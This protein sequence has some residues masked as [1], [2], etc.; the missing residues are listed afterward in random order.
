[1]VCG[2]WHYQCSGRTSL[3][4]QLGWITMFLSPAGS[5]SNL[6]NII[7]SLCDGF[8]PLKF[9]WDWCLSKNTS[10]TPEP[11]PFLV[12]GQFS[13]SRV[14]PF[15]LLRYLWSWIIVHN[16]TWHKFSVNWMVYI[17]LTTN[18]TS[19]GIK[20]LILPNLLGLWALFLGTDHFFDVVDSLSVDELV[21]LIKPVKYLFHSVSPH[22]VLT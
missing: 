22:Y 3:G 20:L 1:M 13:W 21:S 4:Q 9:I 19:L 7:Q 14:C 2:L 11:V 15:L 8:I 5:Q 18:I 16:V 17:R 6:L 12:S 10:C